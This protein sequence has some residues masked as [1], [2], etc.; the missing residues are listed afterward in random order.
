MKRIYLSLL[1][2]TAFVTTSFG[3][4]VYFKNTTETPVSIWVQVSTGNVPYEGDVEFY[5]DVVVEPGDSVNMEVGDFWHLYLLGTDLV[6][7]ESWDSDFNPP[8]DG[9]F[10]L[11]WVGAFNGGGF[12]LGTLTDLNLPDTAIKIAAT[13]FAA[14]LSFEGGTWAP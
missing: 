10:Q 9:D 14:G 4:S 11:D 5:E 3:R 2:L 7:G 13:R 6:T 8:S 1:L 12:S